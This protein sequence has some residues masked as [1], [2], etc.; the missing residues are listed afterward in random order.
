MKRI[1]IA[2]CLSFFAL[3]SCEKDDICDPGGPTTPQLVIQFYNAANPAQ[4]RPVNDLKVI[5]IGAEKAIEFNPDAVEEE[6][7][8]LVNSNSI[9]IPLRTTQES[10]SYAFIYN[11]D[12]P[13]AMVSDTITFHYTGRE[14]YVSRACGFR[15]E[16][17]FKTGVPFEL[18]DVPGAGSGHWIGDIR[19]MQTIIEDENE[20]HV[21]FFF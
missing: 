8:Y 18:N 11:A 9:K 2:A 20:T 5:G 17:T 19:I 12:D 3:S 7:R 16:F 1:L 10:T 4:L 6:D 13:D 15:K 21:R 14:I